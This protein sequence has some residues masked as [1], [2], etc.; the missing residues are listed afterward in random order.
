MNFKIW[1]LIALLCFVGGNVYSQK[2]NAADETIQDIFEQYSAETDEE[3]DY[4]SFYNDLIGFLEMPIQMNSASRE[5]LEKLPFLSD[6]Q[7][8]NILAYLY[9]NKRF[10][11]LYELQLVEGLDMTDVRR[12]LPFVTLGNANE[13]AEKI[14]WNEIFKYGK[15]DVLLRFDK[16]A[17]L[18]KGYEAVL[19]DSDVME[20][21]YL[22]SPVYSSLKYNFKYKNKFSLG[23]VAEKDAGEQFWGDT[24]KGFD[25]YSAH[26]QLNDFWKFKTI[27]VGDYRASF[28]QGLVFNM[29]YGT[30]KSSYV[31]NV[32]NRS[33]GLKK[34]SST[35]EFN[36]LRGVGATMKFK[37]TELS[38]F[39]SYRNMD[40]DTASEQF[41]SF[42]KTGLHRTFTENDK[43]STIGMQNLGANV[44]TRIKMA[45]FG[46]TMAHSTLSSVYNPDIAP[47]N[48]N[49]FR[50]DK[51]TTAGVDYRFRVAT[52]NFFGE[53]AY[54]SKNGLASVNGILFSPLST[55][56]VVALW[57]Y[58][59]PK[60][61][62]FYANAFAENSRVNN[63]NGFY[64]GAE[65]RPF[66][67]WKFAVYA[68]SYQFPWLK[69][70]VNAPS[71]GS[72]YLLQ[73]DFAPNRTVQMLWRVKYEQKQKNASVGAIRTQYDYGKAAFR[74]QLNF[75]SGSFSS[76]NLLELSYS[77]STSKAVSWGFAAYQDLSYTFAKLPLTLNARCMYFDAP[78]YDNRF[79]LY[80]KDILYAFSIPMTY[81][82][83][84][85][86]YL[87]LKIELFDRL[88]IWFKM[89]QTVY[90]SSR[91]T[92]G[93][94]NE[95]ID[96]NRKT[97]YRMLLKYNF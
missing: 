61:D 70:G 20:T 30:S 18:K 2:E 82:A 12:L 5:N 54:T 68:D 88:S 92:I 59:S 17:Q 94:A 52:L 60:Y 37:N 4:E 69:Y 3:I 79:Y 47:Y 53:S 66:S 78:N 44:S 32:V 21:P 11:S 87:N 1:L 89:A 35:D 25:S 14:Y 97:D 77:D 42:Y 74:Y 22:G 29:G 84:V 23:A 62:T 48:L 8:E 86:Y 63:E 39:Y 95:A 45:R 49:Y 76:K 43:R 71:I 28:G 16:T 24:H 85:R 6:I 51:L 96:G 73:A 38:C 90:E 57:R 13:T 46:F 58:Y 64:I 93:S 41:S 31:L 81:G 91:K 72:D 83:G 19:D 65:I 56:S 26:F 75:N 80:E 67:K 33:N 9:K 55:V 10:N 40:S 34:F 27:V 7:I 36:F 15:S 50:G